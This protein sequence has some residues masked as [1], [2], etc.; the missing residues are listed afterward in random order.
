MM[1]SNV[2]A[3]RDR[4]IRT[5]FRRCAGLLAMF[6]IAAAAMLIAGTPAR[7][8]TVGVFELRPR[9][10]AQ[11]GQLPPMCLDVAH[12]SQAHLAPVIQGT[13]VGGP[14]QRWWFRS[15]GDNVWE[16]HPLHSNMCLDVAHQSRAHAAP[17][18]QADCWGGPNQRWRQVGANGIFTF[19]PQHIPPDQPAMCLDVAH[20]SVAHLASIVQARCSGTLNQSWLKLSAGTINV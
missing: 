1:L 13:C 12:R 10:T 4:R 3:T 16:I 6:A 8:E 7:A 15:V 2:T 19:Q 5:A 17:V 20:N 18:V 14:N 11:P 9:H